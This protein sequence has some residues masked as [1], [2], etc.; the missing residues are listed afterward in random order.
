M[1]S[2]AT[3]RRVNTVTRRLCSVPLLLV[4]AVA[5]VV[6]VPLWLPFAVVIDL[7][8]GRWR[9]PVAR[10][11]AFATCWAWLETGGVAA[12]VWLWATG[13]AADE[14]RHVRLQRWWALNLMRA[15]RTTTG[16]PIVRPD[17]TPLAPGP[18]VMLSRHASLADSLVS[19]WAVVDV[20]GLDPHYVL[21]RELLADPCLDI[22]GNRLRNHFLDREAPD[23]SVELD[24]LRAL[25]AG[26]G[27]RDVAV[28]FPEGTRASAQKRSRALA[29]IG[30][31][32]P[33]RAERMAALRH[34]LPPRHAGSAA[35]IDGCPSA[36]VVLAWHVGLDGFDTFSGIMTRL[37]RSPRP[38]EFHM[39]RVPRAQVPSSPQAFGEWLDEQ[40]LQLDEEVDRL[41][42]SDHAAAAAT[43]GGTQ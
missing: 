37:A 24:S 10:L 38:I 28:I 11:L 26:M 39:R 34:L 19:A 33:A 41:L 2:T 23:A 1:P 7:V 8:R 15:L 3:E 4:A 6:L 27:P 12:S 32:D 5:L 42:R 9:C 13:R 35:L 30:Q 21:K 20:A 29:K 18:V 14:A 43:Q 16:V 36:D 25:S 31:R 22:V 40:W 17:A